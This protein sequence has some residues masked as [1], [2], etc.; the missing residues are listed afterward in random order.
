MLSEIRNILGRMPTF[1]EYQKI[2]EMRKK[3]FSVW[4]ICDMLKE[5]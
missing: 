1:G 2:V 5:W 3:G 4:D